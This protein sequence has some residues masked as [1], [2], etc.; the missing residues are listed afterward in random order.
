MVKVVTAKPGVKPTVNAKAVLRLK[1][2]DMIKDNTFSSKKAIK[3]STPDKKSE[4]KE[5]K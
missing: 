5:T 3:S 1:L 4:K 2:L